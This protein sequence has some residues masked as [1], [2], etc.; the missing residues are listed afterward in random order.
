MKQ[1]L[2]NSLRLRLCLL[3]A[4]I[5]CVGGKAWG[6][7]K[8]I[9]S[10]NW[11]SVTNTA[12]EVKNV[13]NENATYSVNE[14]GAEFYT[15]QISAGGP[16]GAPELMIKKNGGA[17]TAIINSLKGCTGNL[18]LSFYSNQ[19]ITLSGSNGVSFSQVGA[20]SN[21]KY[22][23]SVKGA[24][25][26]FSITFTMSKSSNAR[27]DDILLIG[28]NGST[29]VVTIPA[30]VLSHESGEV[31][32]GTTVTITNSNNGYFYYYTTDGVNPE[33]DE[34]GSANNE[35]TQVFPESGLVINTNTNLKVIATDGEGHVSSI[36]SANYTIAE[37][38]GSYNWVETSISELT[39]SDVF[40]IVG[41]S[42]AMT[43]NNGTESAP[44]A[45]SV[46]IADG[47]ITSTVGDNLKWKVSGNATD[48]YT[49]YP[50]GSTT[51]WLY[52][53]TT[54][55]SSSNNNMRVGTGDRK[56]FKQNTNGYF[57]TNDTH[58]ARYIS[59]YN[60]TD[61]RGYTTTNSAVALKFYKRVSANEPNL[62]ASD[63]ELEYNATSGTITYTLENA[64]G[65]TMSANP[66]AD[67][68]TIGTIGESVPFTC[69]ANSTASERTATVTLTYTLTTGGTLTATVTVTQAA[70]P[71][72]VS[73]IAEV[74]SQETGSVQTK[75]VVTSV[76][77]K[78]A[79]IQD[80]TAAIAVHNSDENLEV[81]VGDEIKVSGTLGTY[82]GL[83]QIQSPTIKVLSNG[84]T[85]T[86]EVM[87]ISEVNASSNQGWLVKIVEAKVTNINNQ[88]VTITQGENNI[89]VR[90]NNTNDITVT[91]NDIITLTGNIG[92]FNTTKQIANPKDIVKKDLITV[93]LT[94]NDVPS[95]IVINETA[96]Y[97]ATANP[98]VTGI[99]YQSSDED[100]VMVDEATGEIAALAL[101]TAT[102]TASYAGDDDYKSATAS[103][104][105]TVV[106]PQHTAKFFIDDEEQTEAE[107][108]VSEGAAITFPTAPETI[109][110]K[111][112]VG[113]TTAAI[114]GETDEAPVLVTS[115]T[116]G[117]ADVT[118]YAVYATQEGEGASS[119]ASLTE[120]EIKANFTNEAHKYDDG[121][122]SYNDTNDG[123]NWTASYNVD[124]ADRPWI[125]IKKDA[126]AYLKINANSNISE[127]KLTITAASNSSGGVTDIT[128]HNPFGGV[129][130]LETEASGNPEGTLGSS[131]EVENNVVTLIPNSSVQELYIQVSAGARIWGVEVTY[132]TPATYSGYC[133]TVPARYALIK[134]GTTGFA[135]LSYNEALDF[136]D[137]ENIYAYTA[138]VSGNE[139]SFTRVYQVPANTGLLLR[140]PQGETE[141]DVIAQVPIIASATAI[142]NNALVA[143]SEEIASLPSVNTED[144]SKN[145]ILNKPSGKNVGFFLAAG[146]KVGANK[147]YLKVPAG[148]SA[149][150]SFAEV[151]GGETDGVNEMTNDELEMT[152]IYN[153]AGQRLQ[154]LQRGVNI[155]GGKKVV[156]K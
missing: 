75:G 37:P 129:V 28:E 14:T 89:V 91:E 60:N 78:T 29:P 95:T 144:N 47:K 4:C 153:L 31:T 145:Y 72:A 57:V 41:N 68:L 124:F 146:K 132:G 134:V 135:T 88:N 55:S 138:T 65:G 62:S 35:S 107:V 110:E 23:Y 97:A 79:Y 17:F 26:G 11:S 39:S 119:T 123:I 102:I 36:T 85:V 133:T 96:T 152:N 63:V 86:P 58:T 16:S 127:V 18:T 149:V 128:K 69:D 139:I 137:V 73:T 20:V 27:L 105:I 125:Q 131:E 104:T 140:N 130:Y 30:P 82:S 19:N 87:T 111:T 44:A 103:Y 142:E 67:W 93:T 12:T 118:Y 56:V 24:T 113:W 101:G 114:D 147:A 120:A 112:F 151:F 115:A 76:N 33:V 10:E 22:T 8:T 50:N 156:V 126:T 150:K 15:T 141:G 106:A 9:W 25:D 49:F 92:C 122:V 3:V 143:V 54:A 1:K 48:G 21:K 81:A 74:R 83:L 109:S 70:N 94:F 148:V 155:V 13:Q 5:L 108:E 80:A 38:A 77:G 99:T 84:N 52:C 98:A 45:V 136:T 71:N 116:M 6:E 32:A 43:N 53:N 7:T 61:W 154:K 66:S 121:A 46:T 2:L 100:V 42:Y 51:T 64:A 40:V 59:I 34:D 90:F 117:T